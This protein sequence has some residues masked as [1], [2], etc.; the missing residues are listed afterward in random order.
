MIAEVQ[1]CTYLAT[2]GGIMTTEQS[3]PNEVFDIH[4]DRKPYQVDHTQYN[5]A[6]LRQLAGLDDQ[7][8]LY[9]EEQGDI[10]DTLIADHDV[11]EL[12]PGQHFYST[13]RHITPGS[14]QKF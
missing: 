4:I 9:R 13:P 12:V 1:P 14:C 7:V 10:E 8:D 11:I 6:A 3:T 5:G 2:L